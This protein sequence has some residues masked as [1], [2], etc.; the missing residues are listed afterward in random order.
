L[1]TQATG[2]VILRLSTPSGDSSV[3]YSF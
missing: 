2:S 3:P 1:G